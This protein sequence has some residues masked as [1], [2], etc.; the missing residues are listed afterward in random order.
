MYMDEKNKA[1][2]IYTELP[3]TADAEL[4][5]DC[6]NNCL[7]IK[8][9]PQELHNVLQEFG[10]LG[11]AVPAVSDAG[12]MIKSFLTNANLSKWDLQNGLPEFY[13]NSLRN[14]AEIFV[15]FGENLNEDIIAIRGMPSAKETAIFAY[16]ALGFSKTMMNSNEKEINRWNRSKL[17]QN[18]GKY[19]K[20]LSI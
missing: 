11:F 2:R 14:G 16:K 7:E 19:L 9:N 20:H 12:N 3:E 17:R 8:M 15:K 18:F 1:V 13:A 10:I 5:T 6:L 4:V